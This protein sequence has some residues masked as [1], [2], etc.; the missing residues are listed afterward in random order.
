MGYLGWDGIKLMDETAI[1]FLAQWH[2]LIKPANANLRP[3][4]VHS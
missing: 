3:Q 4:F 1:V 2:P